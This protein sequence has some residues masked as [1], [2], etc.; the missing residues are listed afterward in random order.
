MKRQVLT[1]VAVTALA[2]TIVVTAG[3]VSSSSG[4]RKAG[5]PTLTVWTAATDAP[6]IRHVYTRF[7]KKFHVKLKLFILPASGLETAVQTKWNSGARPDILEYHPTSLFWALN[8]AKNMLDLSKM[9]YVKQSGSLYKSLGR[10]NGHVYAAITQDPTVFG[11]YYNKN[12]LASDGLSAPKSYADLLHIC[13]VLKQKAPSIAPIYESGGS[14][15]PTQIL[16]GLMYVAQTEKDNNYGARLLAKQTTLADPQ[17]PLVK[18]LTAYKKLH[19]QGCFNSDAVTGTFETSMKAVVAGNAAMTFLP[20]DF[21]P[22]LA[23]Q[24]GGLAKLDQALGWAVPSSTRPVAPWAGGPKGT[25]YVP[26]TG[27]HAKE[28]LALKFITYV[29]GPGYQA[30]LNE[31]KDYPLISTGKQAPG[32]SQLQKAVALSYKTGSLAFNTNLPGFNT[33]FAVI[34]GKIL[35]GEA[36]PEQA[37][38]QS[39]QFLAQG[40]HAAHLK[41]W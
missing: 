9:S 32:A 34:M 39:Q 14:Q 21:T 23:D 3:A 12:V 18:A 8:P 6:A 35:S 29:T 30:Y 10:L 31:S 16:G 11:A 4:S 25:W 20:S 40:A 19:E 24:V 2:L 17:G 27:N 5:T 15:W 38:Q 1:A 33:Q 22:L 37:G 13:A 41:G 7:E 28:A 36:T 26:K